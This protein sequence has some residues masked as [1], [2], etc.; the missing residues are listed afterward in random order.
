MGL[1]ISVGLLADL[2]RRDAEGLDHQR[3]AFARL[4]RA[5]AAEGVEWHESE[6]IDPPDAHTFSGGLPYGYLTRLRRILVVGRL[7]EP[8][9]PADAIGA[10]R[11]DDCVKIQ[12]ETSMLASHLLCH[13][14][15]AGYYVP[16]D[17]GDPLFLPEEANVDGAGMV[18]A[19]PR[20]LAELVGIA[21]AIG[22]DLDDEGLPSGT[23]IDGPFATERFA[24]SQLC[25]ACRASITGGHAIAFH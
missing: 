8:V 4:G 10:G 14:D 6:T 15:D 13:A 18:G 22:V 21:A 16:V 7:G 23:D 25:R 11:Y 1:S 9:T 3:R 5:L 24:W 20:L 17:F 19:S 2:A 12:D